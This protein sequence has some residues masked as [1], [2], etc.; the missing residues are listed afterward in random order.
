MMKHSSSYNLKKKWVLQD[1]EFT[2]FGALGEQLH[3]V[4]FLKC[5][6]QGAGQVTLA[7]ILAAKITFLLLI[8][9]IQHF[10]DRHTF[11]INLRHTLNY[12]VNKIFSLLRALKHSLTYQV[13]NC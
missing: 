9:Y 4:P 13:Q 3:M 6:L 7:E 2:D 8:P 10:P 12:S 5:I 11:G 1:T